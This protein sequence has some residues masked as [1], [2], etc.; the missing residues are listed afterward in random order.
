MG[1]CDANV[2]SAPSRALL[3]PAEMLVTE[4]KRGARYAA[5]SGG[6]EEP[7]RLLRWT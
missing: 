7:D 5:G 4:R 6:V 2:L 1:L 3:V